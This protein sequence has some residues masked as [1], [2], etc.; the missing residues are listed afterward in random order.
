M[1]E[2]SLSAEAILSADDRP[3]ERFPVPEW[4]GYVW[5]RVMSGRER[6]SFEASCM[7]G[8]VANMTNVR[9]KLAALAI[10]DHDGNALFNDPKDIKA[11]GEK[12]G[13]VL[14]RIFER[15]SKI[16][17]IGTADMEELAGNLST[18]QSG[19]SGTELPAPLAVV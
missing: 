18:D 6:D 3:S 12:S 1:S 15:A 4:G 7:N 10:C 2:K 14:D 9:A 13:A 16:N 5:L 8:Q 17:H 19:D 11:L